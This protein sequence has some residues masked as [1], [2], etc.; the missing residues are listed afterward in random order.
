MIGLIVTV[1]IDISIVKVYDLV[2]KSFISDETKFLLF[3]INTS[4]CIALEFIIIKYLY[5][6]FK[7]YRWKKSLKINLLYR[8][9]FISLLTIGALM[10]VLIFQQLYYNYYKIII[11]ILIVI[12][13]Y[14]IASTFIIIL[15][16]LFLS[17]YKSQRNKIIFLYFIS[18][19]LIAFNLVM[20]AT[21]TVVKL[22]D[23]PDEIR[24]FSGGTV[25]LS[26]GKYEF[27]NNIYKASSILSFISIW[28]TTALLMNYYREKLINIIV[29]WILLSIPL[30]Y[31]LINYIYQYIFTGI[32]ISYL[33]ID[34]I[35]VSIL[36]TTF[37]S[38]SKPIGGLT[39]AA[40]FWNISKIVNYEKNIKSSMVI[41]GWGILLIFGANQGLVQTLAPYP[42]FG[43]MTI[44]VL[45]L[46]G[47]LMLLGIYNSAK[48]VSVNDNL[49]KSIYKHFS[50][51]RLLGLIGQA[52]MKKEIEGIVKEI[53]QHKG[54]LERE[55][56]IPIALDEKALKKYI[57]F[58]ISETKK[59]NT[60]LDDSK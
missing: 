14:I 33:T 5:T 9:S 45:I 2:D 4:V 40:V 29:Y 25:D 41:S 21:I 27:L 10:T 37:L 43:L 12:I 56:N 57:T 52:E 6:S 16:I 46:G 58:V 1:V 59:E 15:S 39:F 20:T 8:I 26:V 3:S 50:E 60:K 17:W 13:S 54:S 55:I 38:L 30:L 7:G 48:L 11:P 22:T 18:M 31:F 51:P 23:R 34:P 19:L 24:K 28:V 44:T 53:T 32:L 47:F 35:T 36:L 42:P 49:R